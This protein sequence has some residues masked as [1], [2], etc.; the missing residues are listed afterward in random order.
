MQRH[1]FGVAWRLTHDVTTAEDL[2]QDTYLKLWTRRDRLQRLESDEAFAVTTLKNIY[3]DS[4]RR[5][6]HELAVDTEADGAQRAARQLDSGADIAR[7]MEASED[8]DRLMDI[9][10]RLPDRQRQAFTMLDIDGMSLDEVA[11]A[12]GLN[13]G[14]LRSIISRARKK[15]REM[16]TNKN[17]TR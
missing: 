9:V 12:T 7:A 17:K 6:H 11:N 4:K 10:D 1:L 14:N 2:V 16:W 8:M 5:Q 3:I 15:V 13:G